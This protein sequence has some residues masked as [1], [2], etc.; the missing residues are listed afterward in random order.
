MEP[1]AEEELR[2]ATGGDRESLRRVLN[3]A[4]QRLRG[5]IRS[6]I[7]ARFRAL[8]DED[9]VLQ[10]TY[11][12]AAQ[13]IET[14]SPISMNAFVTWFRRIAENNLRDAIRGLDRLKRGGGRSPAFAHP[15]G[16]YAGLLVNLSAAGSTPS[17]HMAKN[18]A[19]ERLKSAIELLPLDYLEVTRRFDLQ[20][21]TVQEVA[22]QLSRSEGA[23]YM[24]RARAHDRLREL[25][26][27]PAD[28]FSDCA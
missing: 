11:L 8:I 17:A 22:R 25:M 18:E 13:R 5:E 26:G 27:A 4:G 14:V 10:V 24:L 6:R 20:G 15:D 3:E 2:R 16:S 12:E 7:G 21:E 9:D 1:V 23:V 28:F 19:V